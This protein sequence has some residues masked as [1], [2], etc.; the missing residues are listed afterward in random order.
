M[1]QE[2]RQPEPH[3]PSSG[4]ISF[5]SA[6]RLVLRILGLAREVSCRSVSNSSIYPLGTFRPIMNNSL[7]EAA[8]H[9]SSRIAG[10]PRSRLWISLALVVAACG[11]GGGGS[12]ASPA[13]GPAPAPAPAP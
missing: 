10:F 3:L 1:R 4:R 11:G 8:S 7:P 12:A 9:L 6:R 2:P 5:V 13:P